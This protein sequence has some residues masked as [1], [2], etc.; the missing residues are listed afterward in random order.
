[1]DDAKGWR[2]TSTIEFRGPGASFDDPV[3]MWLACHERVRRFASMLGR[4]RVHM[5]SAGADEEARASAESIRRYFNEAAPRH[6]EDEEADMFPLLRARCTATDAAVIATIERV[7]TE[8]VEMAALWRELDAVLAR[9]GAGSSAPLADELVERFESLYDAHIVAEETV[10]LPAMRRVL[11]A[12]DW[13]AI[14]ISMARR[15]GLDWD[16]TDTVRPTPD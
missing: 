1:V 4:L 11:G 10:L 3:E 2:M 14:G 16:G 5:V 9:I 12:G 13:Q 15:R 8:H 7:E 6:H